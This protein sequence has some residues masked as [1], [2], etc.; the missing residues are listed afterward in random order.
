MV[1]NVGG[2]FIGIA[3][4]ELIFK[5]E[6]NVLPQLELLTPDFGQDVA[7]VMEKLSPTNTTRSPNLPED[8]TERGTKTDITVTVLA[9]STR[10]APG[11][12]TVVFVGV[13]YDIESNKPFDYSFNQSRAWGGKS[14][15]VD[16]D[17]ISIE[18]VPDSAIRP[19]PTTFNVDYE[20][21]IVEA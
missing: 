12:G 7:E 1:V 13:K 2:G 5:A 9:A 14:V 17:R 10:V 19:I 3:N 8:P 18:N 11:G 4:T 15:F 20:F 21:T 16:I 6:E